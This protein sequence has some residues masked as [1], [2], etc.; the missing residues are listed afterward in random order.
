MRCRKPLYS[1]AVAALL[2]LAPGV[3]AAHADPG[4]RWVS[5]LSDR[6]QFLR[7]LL[8]DSDQSRIALDHL[9][10]V[11]S[12]LVGITF[13]LEGGA[14]LALA[15]AGGSIEVDGRGVG[16]YRP[17]GAL[18]A[19]WRRL[20][21]E[22]ARRETPEAVSLMHAW[23]P[24]GL[25]RDELETFDLLKEQL[26]PLSGPTTARIRPQ[27]IPPAD[28][29]GLV[30]DLA[31]L[32]DIRRLEPLLRQAASADAAS[33]RITVPNGQARLGH[34]SIGSGTTVPGHLLVLKGNADVYGTLE[35]NL[36][37]VDGDVIVHPGAVV[38]GDVLA[39]AGDV[40]DAG[41]EIR[42]E[43][44]TF[45]PDPAPI[46]AAPAAP[47]PG[48]S[49]FTRALH[50]AAGLIGVFVTLSLLGF[51]LVLFGKQPLEVVSDTVGH[52]FGRAFVVGLLAEIMVLPTF[53]MIFVGLLLSVVGVLLIPFALIAYAL[54]VLV[55]LLGGFLAVAH[56][57]GEAYTRR[58][59][60]LGA[61]V[62]SANSYRYIGTG[63]LTLLALWGSWILFGWVPV[64]G[65]LVFAAAALATWLLA[66]VGFGAALLSRGGFRESFAGR[67]LPPEALTDEYLWATPQFGVPAA[68]RPGTRTPPPPAR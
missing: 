43:I 57:M 3:P 8:Q 15:F 29:S 9:V 50:N 48:V 30:I 61:L 26:A 35:G 6:I 45:A 7:Q 66:T 59:L 60:A 65:T 31:R 44:R 41:G 37:A 32:D 19:A 63:L 23:A 21:L 56:A 54:I 33:L 10:T 46:P 36:A 1:L 16:N 58:R 12:S 13:E 62:S 14:R 5:G 38:T 68:R 51:G 53:G 25:S 49:G 64:A 17:G 55:A 47:E 39:L 4:D 20:V 67:I 18:E 40:R 34:F 52:S 2:G 24:E 42:G 11:S 27:L 22:A 28:A